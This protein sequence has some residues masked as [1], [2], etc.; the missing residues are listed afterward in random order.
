MALVDHEAVVAELEAYIP[1]KPHHGSKDLALQLERIKARNTLDEALLVRALRVHGLGELERLLRA[2]RD[3][4][5]DPAGGSAADVDAGERDHRHT[6]TEEVTDGRR[7]EA[8]P[9]H[10]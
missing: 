1:S 2:A 9:A 5:I 3:D 10:V 7:H 6:T 8:A 4:L